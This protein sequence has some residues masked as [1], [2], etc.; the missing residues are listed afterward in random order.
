MIPA[1]HSS[2]PFPPHDQFVSI[3]T[4]P[5]VSM[6]EFVPEQRYIS[7]GADEDVDYDV[8][9]FYPSR[10]EL[11]ARP[12]F[13]MDWDDDSCSESSLSDCSVTASPTN[14]VGPTFAFPDTVNDNSISEM[15]YSNFFRTGLW[16][17]SAHRQL[18][19]LVE[20]ALAKL[21]FLRRLLARH[22]SPTAL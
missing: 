19:A 8:F 16:A 5:S 6:H 14:S 21:H 15:G 17:Q 4:A 7:S 20:K 9:Y 1:R 11:R 10:N 12:A 3:N 2:S 18:D 13:Y 22:T